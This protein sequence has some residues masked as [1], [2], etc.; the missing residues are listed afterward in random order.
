MSNEIEKKYLVNVNELKQS[1]ELPLILATVQRTDKISQGYLAIEPT[2][3]EVR[4]RSKGTGENSRYYLTVKSGQGLV[5]GEAETEISREQF[6]VLWPMTA[7]RR[8][9]KTRL[10]LALADDLKAEVDFYEGTLQGLYTAE[11]EFPSEEVANA[12]APPNWFGIDITCDKRFKNQKLAT[13]ASVEE[14]R[15]EPNSA[16]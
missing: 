5:R 13:L 10:T 4:L 2:G 1:P 15:S 8:V 9:E 6:E 16:A 7:G 12:F 11:V 14:L 3:S